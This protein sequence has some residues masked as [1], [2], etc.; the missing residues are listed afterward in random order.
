MSEKVCIALASVVMLEV[1]ASIAACLGS[2]E[3]NMDGQS[4]NMVASWQ[5][6]E[7]TYSNTLMKGVKYFP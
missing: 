4:S 6:A 1:I 7:R 3:M 5:R 2:G